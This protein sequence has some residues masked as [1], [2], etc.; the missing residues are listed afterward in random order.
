MEHTPAEI[1]AAV[2]E[3]ALGT[4]A[5]EPVRVDGVRYEKDAQGW[6]QTRGEPA[7]PA[8][9][10]VVPKHFQLQLSVPA[11]DRE[12]AESVLSMVREA[13]ERDQTLGGR[14]RSAR[15]PSSAY[16]IQEAKDLRGEDVW[17]VPVPVTVFEVR[18]KPGADC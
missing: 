3:W 11:D 12:I 1:A 16:R 4:L 15:V 5:S 8:R 2:E 6:P 13:I 14:V 17:F 7:E 10:Q 18:A 9:V